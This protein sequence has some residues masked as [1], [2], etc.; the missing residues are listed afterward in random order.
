ML[1][2]EVLGTNEYEELEQIAY[3]KSKAFCYS[4]GIEVKKKHCPSCGSDDSAR[5]LESV[6]LDFGISWIIE[7]LISENCSPVDPEFAD[8]SLRDCY[9]ETVKLGWI[10]V[11]PI[12]AIKKL[13]PLDYRL[14]VDEY[15]D[16]LKADNEIVEVGNNDYWKDDILDFIKSN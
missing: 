1:L 7:H 6:G 8:Q 12:D 10:E 16:S 2:N 3:K 15:T 14:A 4:C 11:D 9:P 13:Y 5:L